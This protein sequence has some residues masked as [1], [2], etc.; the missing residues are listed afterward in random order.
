MDDA[1]RTEMAAGYTFDEPV[2][3]LGSPI[4]GDEVLADVRV[5]VPLS[6]INRH[7]LIAGAT[8]TGKTKTLQLLAGQLSALG[9]PVFAVDVKGDLSGVGAPGDPDEPA[10]RERGSS[11][12]SSPSRRRATRSRS[13]R[14]RGRRAPTS[15]PASPRS[16]RC[17]WARSSTSTTPRR[18]SCRSSSA[19]ATTRTCRC[20]TSRTSGR[21]SSSSARTRASR[22]SRTSAGS[23]RR[24]SASSCGRSSRS[25]RR[26]PATSSASPS[27]TPTT[28]SGRPP[29][30]KGIVTL[31]EVADVMDRPRLYS[32]FVLW[33][34]AQLYET[35]PE[36]GDLPEAQARV[37]LRRGAPPVRA[38]RPSR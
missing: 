8:G 27:S 10:G 33:M 34:L 7:G 2:V 9:V 23:A 29:D 32:T 14:C 31:L 24:A 1:F 28:S 37:L 21:R 22:C 18:R 19:T 5:Q 4:V 35:L 26:A 36:V 16:G 25:S 30:G 3:V 12:S 38:T 17:C 11:R 15:G 13:C 20:S 6:R